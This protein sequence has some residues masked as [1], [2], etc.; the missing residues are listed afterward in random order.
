MPDPYDVFL[1]SPT[2]AGG[3]VYF[4][5]GDGNVYA[6]DAKTGALQWSSRPA[7]WCTPRPL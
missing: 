2:L 3:M 4:G 5:S 6:L 7:T 1:S